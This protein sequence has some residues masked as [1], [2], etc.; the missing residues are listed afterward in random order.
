[1][2]KDDVPRN[3]KDDRKN[4]LLEIQHDISLEKNESF[5]GQTLQ[6]LVDQNGEDVSV[7]RTEFDS[8]EIDN[9]VHIKDNAETGTFVKVDIKR[10]NEYELIGDLA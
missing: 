1:M 10:A 4:M 5:I 2:L 3:V 9:I 8:P 6:V 7:G